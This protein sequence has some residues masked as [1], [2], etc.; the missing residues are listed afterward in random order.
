ME[1]DATEGW[2]ITMGNALS[3]GPKQFMGVPSYFDAQDVGNAVAGAGN[4]LYDIA[5]SPLTASE[6]LLSAIGSGDRWAPGMAMLD[7]LANVPGPT[8]SLLAKLGPMTAKGV[9][10]LREFSL[11]SIISK[12]RNDLENAMIPSKLNVISFPERPGMG[13][14][15]MAEENALRGKSDITTGTTP[16]TQPEG[17][18]L[19]VRINNSSPAG[20]GI[21][22]YLSEDG[23]ILIQGHWYSPNDVAYWGMPNYPYER[24]LHPSP[25]EDV[26][27]VFKKNQGS[28]E[29]IS[30]LY[31]AFWKVDKKIPYNGKVNER[32]R[33]VPEHLRLQI[34]NMEGDGVRFP[35]KKQIEEYLLSTDLKDYHEFAFNQGSYLHLTTEPRQLTQKEKSGLLAW[36]Q[37]GGS[38]G[39]TSLVS[40]ER[41]QETK[42]WGYE[43]SMGPEKRIKLVPSPSSPQE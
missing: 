23:K 40:L 7:Y 3:G 17:G 30:R 37:N 14:S 24:I 20:G 38:L 27:D 12:K 19:K 21:E 43:S 5:R 15:I 16:Q 35:S 39:R 10:A 41:G 8:E 42:G 36:E 13:G 34:R 33:N 18:V 25:S 26:L 2:K 31:D 9:N 29:S 32:Y 22:G 1:P 28:D 6:N 11:P 4:A